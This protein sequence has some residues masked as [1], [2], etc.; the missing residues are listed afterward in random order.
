MITLCCVSCFVYRSIFVYTIP[1]RTESSIKRL[2]PY[3]IIGEVVPILLMET[4][5]VYFPKKFQD[6][7]NPLFKSLSILRKN[8]FYGTSKQNLMEHDDT[9]DTGEY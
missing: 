3:L 2:T 6:F 4:F 1:G 5:L 9:G 7:V 8:N